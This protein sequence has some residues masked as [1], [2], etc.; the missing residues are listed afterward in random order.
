M[1]Y[2]DKKIILSLRKN[3]IGTCNNVSEKNEEFSISH[4]GKN[5][6]RY[7]YMLRK[8]YKSVEFFPSHFDEIH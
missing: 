3:S 8:N 2:N 7:M 1:F 4:F 6:P 5:C